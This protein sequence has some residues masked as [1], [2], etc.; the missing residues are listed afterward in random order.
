MLEELLLSVGAQELD[1]YD[2]KLSYMKITEFHWDDP[3][4]KK[5]TVY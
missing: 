3:D 5:D 4:L 1:R 2:Y